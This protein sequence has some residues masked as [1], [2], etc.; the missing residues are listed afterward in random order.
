M[1]IDLLTK[2]ECNCVFC[3]KQT[4][5]GVESINELKDIL[6]DFNESIIFLGG[7]E[8]FNF[9]DL[10]LLIAF[11]KNKAPDSKIIIKSSGCFDYK[12]LPRVLFEKIEIIEL[13][14][15]SCSSEIHNKIMGNNQAWE[16]LFAFVDFLKENNLQNKILF[17]TMVLKDN[18]KELF[19]IYDFVLDNLPDQQYFKIIYPLKNI[20]KIEYEKI[21]VP[22]DL[23]IKQLFADFPE[24]ILQNKIELINF[25]PS[26]EQIKFR[27]V[28]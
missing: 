28:L 25:Q 20:S 23:V 7:Q 22:Q 1:N 9:K 13:P 5:K 26:K 11:L 14:L 24:D 10:D 3:D 17:H 18:F 16:L 27:N 19:A 8:P 12:K 6:E 15:Y 2:C 21:I 4:V